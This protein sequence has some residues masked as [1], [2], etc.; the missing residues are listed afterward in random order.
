MSFFSFLL[1]QYPLRSCRTSASK[2]HIKDSKISLPTSLPHPSLCLTS[3]SYSLFY[4]LLLFRTRLHYTTLLT[5]KRSLLHPCLILLNG[6]LSL[7]MSFAFFSPL[8]SLL[9]FRTL[10]PTPHRKQSNTPTNYSSTSI[11]HSLLPPRLA[12]THSRCPSPL[13]IVLF[14][15]TSSAFYPPPLL[16]LVHISVL[17]INT[18]D[19]QPFPFSCLT[20][21]LSLSIPSM[22]SYLRHAPCHLPCC[23]STCSI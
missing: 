5:V 23:L 6:L 10:A 3:T 12:C 13:S 8:Y 2:L 19:R 22:P 16:S 18:S 21:L 7:L 9:F 17:L 11:S 4:P 1:P 15:L 14:F 20:L